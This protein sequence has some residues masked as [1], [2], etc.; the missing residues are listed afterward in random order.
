MGSLANGHRP[1]GL[2]WFGFLS[3]GRYLWKK[4]C[5]LGYEWCNQSLCPPEEQVRTTSRDWRGKVRLQ[6]RGNLSSIEDSELDPV[7][8]GQTLPGI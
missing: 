4:L 8:L 7:L 6:E 3:M 2:P 5:I 1:S